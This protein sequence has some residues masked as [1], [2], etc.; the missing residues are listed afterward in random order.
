MI[1]YTWEIV[2][3]PIAPVLKDYTDVVLAVIWKLIGT[4]ENKRTAEVLC[5]TFFLPP[6][7]NFIPINEVTDEIL[8]SWIS[9][10]EDI[11]RVQSEIES[12]IN[13]Q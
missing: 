6:S 10:K 12:K 5:T 9:D 7:D 4:D 13:K 1:T 8:V 2:D 11:T 3:K